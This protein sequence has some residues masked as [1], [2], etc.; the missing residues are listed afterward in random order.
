MVFPD[1][2]SLTAGDIPGGNAGPAT[3]GAN[4]SASGSV[5]NALAGTNFGGMETV[6]YLIIGAMAL[7]A[8]VAW[9]KL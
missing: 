7:A 6:D 3:S 5:S 4:G 1:I 2:G 8:I 9:K